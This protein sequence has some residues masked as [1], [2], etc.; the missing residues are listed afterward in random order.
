MAKTKKAHSRRKDD[1]PPEIPD[2]DSYTGQIRV[3]KKG[4]TIKGLKKLNRKMK[5]SQKAMRKAS[6]TFWNVRLTWVC[7]DINMFVDLGHRDYVNKKEAVKAFKDFGAATEDGL[8]DGCE[9]LILDLVDRD[10]V[11]HENR[12]PRSEKAVRKVLKKQM[13]DFMSL[14]DYKRVKLREQI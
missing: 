2:E 9:G 14:A 6:K 10:G 7:G 13:P 1:F 4:A 3:T 8:G 5:R 11:M 12:Y